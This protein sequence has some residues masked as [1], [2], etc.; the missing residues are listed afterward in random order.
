LRSESGV[1]VFRSV[2]SWT[3]THIGPNG[4]SSTEFA[5]INRNLEA[6]IRANYPDRKIECFLVPRSFG[7]DVVTL[8]EHAL[9]GADEAKIHS[10]AVSAR[11][12]IQDA[13]HSR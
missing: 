8:S 12:T 2:S 9:A 6:A 3:I 11:T 4:Y 5:A 7:Y 10:L 1:P 13:R